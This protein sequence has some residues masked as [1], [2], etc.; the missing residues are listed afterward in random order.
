[1]LEEPLNALHIP[2]NHIHP[3]PSQP[4]QLLPADLAPALATGTSPADVLAQIRE[5]SKRD[6]WLRERLDELDG[7]ADS[8][9][10][11]GLLQPIRVIQDGNDVY[12]IEEGERRWW[13]HHVLVARGDSRF[14]TIAAFVVTPDREGVGVL[15]R[16]VAENVLRSGFT[17]IELARAMAARM[18]EVESAEPL[19][20]RREIEKRVGRENAM[21]DRRVRQFLAL[22][23]LPAAVQELAQVARLSENSL[24]SLV[25]IKDPHRLVAAAHALARPP[26]PSSRQGTRR[27]KCPKAKRKQ[28]IGSRIR[29]KTAR[30]VSSVTPLVALA[31]RMQK[32]Q[33]QR[34]GSELHSRVKRNEP[35]REA[36]LHLLEILNCG[37][38]G[39]EDGQERRGKGSKTESRQVE[40]VQ[41]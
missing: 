34:V 36:M 25:S 22:L 4:R 21:S 39:I 33:V 17:A 7:L 27:G 19:L 1:M 29:T 14:Q 13:A 15:R 20:G 40:T 9:A 28:D 32:E 23:K 31:R 30:S 5:R 38:K 2:I 11:D 24:R 12:R 35:E 6:P 3:D 26:Q 16:R 8:I 41:E 10:A 37:L 18:A